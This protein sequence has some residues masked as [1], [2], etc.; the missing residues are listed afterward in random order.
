M[1]AV[2]GFSAQ[3]AFI[4]FETFSLTLK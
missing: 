3:P 2:L 4:Y 1:I